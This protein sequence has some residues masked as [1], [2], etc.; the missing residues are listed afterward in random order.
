MKTGRTLHGG[1]LESE[2]TRTY[3]RYLARA[4]AEQRA[5]G[6]PVR[7]L[8]LANE[9]QHDTPAYPSMLLSSD[10]SLAVAVELPEAL[11]SYGVDDLTV[12]GH[13]H[14]WDDTAYPSRLLADPTGSAVLGGV[15]FH[16]YA[17]RPEAQQ[18]V[19]TAF[20]QH[21]VWMTECSGDE[22]ATDGDNLAWNA[23]SLIIGNL[24]SSGSSL[25]LWLALDPR[26]GP[27]NG[28]CSTCRGVVT[29]DPATGAVSY[30]VEYYVLGQVTKAAR[31]GAVRIG[32]TSFGAGRVESVAFRNP[33]G[34]TAVVLHNNA[35]T[36]QT[37][38]V[39]LAG[40]A[41]S[42]TLPA[43]SVQTLLW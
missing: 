4:V 29:A 13:D 18:V 37:A 35:G 1:T 21:E 40:R 16:C 25:L 20:P 5:A 38:T 43:G 11:Q 24:R 34:T 26:N 19:A 15:A 22:W 23:H 31:P 6:V 28:G 39:V 17:G 9:P 7:A 2:H 10:Q 14:N 3:A 36:K 30:N 42:V 32:S 12:L 27:T 33:D 8:T 41:L